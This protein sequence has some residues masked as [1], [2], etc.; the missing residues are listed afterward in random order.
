MQL[1]NGHYAIGL[2]QR[3]GH[4]F[5]QDDRLACCCRELNQ[6]GV[7]RRLCC[8]RHRLHICAGKQTCG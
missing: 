1:H 4:G 7:V 2:G 3:E 8:N 5:L 6:L